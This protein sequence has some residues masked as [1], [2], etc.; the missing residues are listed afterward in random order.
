M[1]S[2]WPSRSCE[3]C[4]RCCASERRPCALLRLEADV[5]TGRRGG[6]ATADAV[7]ATAATWRGKPRATLTASRDAARLAFAASSLEAASIS[8]QSSSVSVARERRARSAPRTRAQFASARLLAAAFSFARGCARAPQ[9]AAAT[10]LGA[11]TPAFMVPTGEVPVLAPQEAAP[12]AVVSPRLRDGHGASH[13]G[14]RAGS[15]AA[16]AG[17]EVGARDV[18]GS[19]RAMSATAA[20][21]W[22]ADANRSSGA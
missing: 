4:V 13:A 10:V 17:A 7:V 21:E 22:S 14:V 3:S 1:P 5:H 15:W 9:A 16:V 18:V 2:K 8:R 20:V 11:V 6:G 12:R 19:S